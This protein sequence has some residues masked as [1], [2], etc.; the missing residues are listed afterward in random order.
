[1]KIKIDGENLKIDD[2]INVARNFYIVEISEKAKHN[3][4][5]SRKILEKFLKNGKTIYG[6]NTGFGSKA[7]VTIPVE[8]AQKLQ[9]NLILSHSCGAGDFL[10]VDTVRAAMLIRANTLCKGYSGVR[11]CVIE[12]LIEMLNKGVTPVVPE[13]GSV[14]ASGDLIPLSHIA[15][16]FIETD[17][18]IDPP[19]IYEGKIERS[20]KI[21]EKLGIKKLKLMQKEGLA[22][23]NGTQVST[24]IGVLCLYDAK[25]LLDWA[26][27]A[28]A[29]T[30]EALKSNDLPFH[31]EIQKVRPHTGQIEIANKLRNLLN[32]SRNMDYNVLQDAYSLR[33]IPQVYGA[34]FDTINFV[35]KILS[36]E[37]NSATDNPL[38]FKDKILSCGN[39][40]GEYIAMALDFLSIAVSEIGSMSER[41]IFRLLTGFLNRGLPS[42]LIKDSGFQSGFMLTQYLCANLCN[43][44][45]VLCH[46]ASCDSIPTCEDQEDFVSMSMTSALKLRKIIENVKTII[47]VE[48]ICATQAIDMRNTKD[49]MSEENKRTYRKIRENVPFI[50]KDTP[51]SDYI[52]KIAEIIR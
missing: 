7:S 52:K 43:E 19:V 20:S 14:G 12:K 30:I 10:P 34:V 41:R 4:E 24:A 28:S 3:I 33:C 50:E 2:V 40:H 9:E 49:K 35:E 36:V 13:K 22:L 37:I 11:L 17:E 5:K 42:F 38:I 32:G 15:L 47:A 25:K 29:L 39:F 51:L 21:F 26:V 18:D 44:N 1:M 45:K 48:L 8:K 6:V 27:R 16:T 46:P 31:E 23:N